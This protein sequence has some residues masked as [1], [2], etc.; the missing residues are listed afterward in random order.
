[1]VHNDQKRGRVELARLLDAL[2]AVDPGSRRALVIALR[3]HDPETRY[4]TTH[5]GRVDAVPV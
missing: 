2:N 4:F 5:D 3:E 1:M